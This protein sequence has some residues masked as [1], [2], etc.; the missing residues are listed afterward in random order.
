MPGCPPESHQIATVIDPC[1]L[2]ATAKPNCFKGAVI[3]AGD[4]TCCVTNVHASVTSKDHKIRPFTKWTPLIPICVCWSRD[5]A[6][7]RRR[8]ADVGIL[9]GSTMHRASAVMVRRRCGRLRCAHHVG[10]ASVIDSRDP[11]EI[12]RIL[13]GIP[14]PA[15]IVYRFNLAH[16]LLRTEKWDE[17]D[18][19]GNFPTFH[20]WSETWQPD[21]LVIDPI[22]RLEGHGKIGRFF[23]TRKGCRHVFPD[24]GIARL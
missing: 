4:S 18:D 14:D 9:S 16:S 24:S 13:D 21:A 19:G 6:T 12:E 7:V 1:W 5:L 15:G 2:C 17:K 8:A 22:T 20:M 3:G 11:D 10:P 23:S